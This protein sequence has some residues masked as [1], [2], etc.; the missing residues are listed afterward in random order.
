MGGGF[1]GYGIV[2]HPNLN[3]FGLE[4]GKL[5]GICLPC[6]SSKQKSQFKYQLEM[7]IWE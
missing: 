5:P 1:R 4:V 3:L 2:I 7:F 6:E